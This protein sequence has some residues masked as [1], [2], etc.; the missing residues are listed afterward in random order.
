MPS[1][2]RTIEARQLEQALR[3]TEFGI[4]MIITLLYMAEIV[5]V[6]PP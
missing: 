5:M 3:L 6:F 1:K 2:I 4:V